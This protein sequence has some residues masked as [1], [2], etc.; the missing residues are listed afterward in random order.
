LSSTAATSSSSSKSI[1][2]GSEIDSNP[3]LSSESQGHVGCSFCTQNIVLGSCKEKVQVSSF[4]FSIERAK[5]TYIG[6]SLL[7][8]PPVLLISTQKP[9][10]HTRIQPTHRHLPHSI[11]MECFQFRGTI[12]RTIMEF[13]G[14]QPSTNR[15]IRDTISIL[16]ST[17]MTQYA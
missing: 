7:E 17:F 3:M 1:S 2:S 4:L 6:D 5:K 11:T 12:R 10:Q 15:I 9:N 13:D 8:I 16:A 14:I